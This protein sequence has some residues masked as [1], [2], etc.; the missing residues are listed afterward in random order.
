ML[1]VSGRNFVKRLYVRD[2]LLTKGIF[3]DHMT[4]PFSKT[5]SVQ[6]LFLKRS[7]QFLKNQMNPYDH[8]SNILTEVFQN[9]PVEGLHG[10]R[11]N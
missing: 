11:S 8:G 1:K 6:F 3:H 7:V 9:M 5:W 4:S 2:R 10:A